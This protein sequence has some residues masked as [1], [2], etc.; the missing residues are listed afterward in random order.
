M[1]R[2]PRVRWGWPNLLLGLL[3]LALV[4]AAVVVWTRPASGGTGDADAR[5][6]SRRQW[7]VTEAASAEVEA[8][9]GVDH[10]RMR[11]VVTRVQDG[12]TG[13]FAEEYAEGVDSLLSATRESRITARAVVRAVALGPVT[14]TRAEV[15]VAADARVTRDGS[16]GREQLRQHRLRLTMVERD[17]RW[18]TEQLEFVR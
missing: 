10:R 6:L 11:E 13:D 5:E 12:A 2:S 1:A 17:G 14:R 3:A 9:L 4:A 15:L 16:A 8:V 7:E 18:L